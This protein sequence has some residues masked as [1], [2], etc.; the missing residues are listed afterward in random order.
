MKDF[1]SA[2]SFK[3]L[4]NSNPVY[5]FDTNIYLDLLRYS[6][7]SSEETL[8]IYKSLQKNMW[9]PNQ[10]NEEFQKNVLIVEGQRTTN[11]KKAVTDSKNAINKCNE[12]IAKQ[13]NIFVKYKFDCSQDIV[14]KVD[15]E[16][17]ALKKSIEDYS[18]TYV[19]PKNSGFLDVQDV[20]DFFNFVYTKNKNNELLPSALFSIYMAGDLRY[21]YKIPPGYMD[22][23]KNNSGS[24]KKGTAIFGDLVLWNEI[25]NFGKDSKQPIVFVTSD[26]KEDWF[27]LE[28]DKPI[29]PRD[30]LI[31]EFAEYTNGNQI[32]IL[33]SEKFIEYIGEVMLIDNASILA[34]MQKDHFADIAIRDNKDSIKE[35]LLDWIDSEDHV[36]LIPFV[37]EINKVTDIKNITLIVQDTTVDVREDANYVVNVKST[38]EFVGAYYDDNFKR[39]TLNDHNESFLFSINI[40]FRRMRENKNST[41]NIFSDAISDLAIISG[42]FEKCDI[43][44]VALESQR[45]TFIKPND[46]DYEIYNYMMKKWDKYEE[47]NS[48]DRAEAMVYIDASE[49]FHCSLLEINRAFSLVENQSTKINLSLNEIDVLALKRFIDIGFMISDDICTFDKKPIKLGQSY[50]IPKSMAP[51]PPEKGKE[52]EVNFDFEV[53]RPEGKYVQIK[54]TT[55]LPQDTDLMFSL[56]NT[57]LNYH[58]NSKVK[59]SEGNCFISD[60]FKKGSNPETNAL[61]SGKYKLEIVVPIANVQPDTVKVILGKNGRNLTGQYVSYD[62]I[63]GNTVTFLKRFSL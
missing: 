13:L 34:E 35:K 12:S 19:K 33:T 9:V 20:I 28:N 57:D 36:S 23:P 47:D 4:Y 54:G 50:P 3:S 61:P 40:S 53:E 10:V 5:I 25:M 11:A 7:K 31:K 30:E 45:G 63:M 56:V 17:T 15:T 46:L 16:L 26:V 62:S 38:A 21:K 37:S 2:E 42:E 55:T 58:A 8:L 59:V 14:S 52:V 18:K 1:I 51:L 39:F 60:I 6:K 29:A 43:D 48:V 49:H 44:T 27:L 41:G 32:C 24:S 22:D